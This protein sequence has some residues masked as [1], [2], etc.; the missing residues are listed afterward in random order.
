MAPS[1]TTAD[2]AEVAIIIHMLRSIGH[3]YVAPSTHMPTK[4]ARERVTPLR[5]PTHKLIVAICIISCLPNSFH[6]RLFSVGEHVHLG[7]C[8]GMY[9]SNVLIVTQMVHII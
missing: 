5:H 3:S 1:T 8:T 4:V 6:F 2:A 9:I 7:M